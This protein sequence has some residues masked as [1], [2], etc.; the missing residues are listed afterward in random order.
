MP[1]VVCEGCGSQHP[2]CSPCFC[3]KI[4]GNNH[5]ARLRPCD[6]AIK[7]VQKSCVLCKN[8][9]QFCNKCH[10]PFATCWFLLKKAGRPYRICLHCQGRP[11]SV[12]SSVCGVETQM[13]AQELL[14]ERS[15]GELFESLD[16]SNDGVLSPHKLI[17]GLKKEQG[18][19]EKAGEAL[20]TAME[21][22]ND[23]MVS[24][25]MWIAALS[26]V[27]LVLQCRNSVN[28]NENEWQHV[29]SGKCYSKADE[30]VSLF[31]NIHQ[32]SAKKRKVESQQPDLINSHAANQSAIEHAAADPNTNVDIATLVNSWLEMSPRSPDPIDSHAATDDTAAGIVVEGCHRDATMASAV[33]SQT[34][35]CMYICELTYICQ[36]RHTC[37]RMW[38]HI[39]MR[40]WVSAEEAW[41]CSSLL[42]HHHH[43]SL[44][45]ISA[46]RPVALEGGSRW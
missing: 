37:M 22:D 5:G 28:V 1:D 32:Q 41:V 23:G 34:E 20:Q 14:R 35:V 9:A 27:A 26:K 11:D 33:S 31:S 6:P 12:A 45:A 21:T 7:R 46:V 25:A 40:A 39:C 42:S 15:G 3:P 36:C 13:S 8:C 4:T 16:L 43:L 10:G 24:K 38:T 2:P 44:I 18:M 17:Y 29:C 19:D 30:C